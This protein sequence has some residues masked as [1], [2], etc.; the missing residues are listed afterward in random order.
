MMPRP[1]R[2]KSAA[3]KQVTSCRM[4]LKE[5]ESKPRIAI[6]EHVAAGGPNDIIKEGVCAAGNYALKSLARAL[7][8]T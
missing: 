1:D 5:P 2:A 6:V 8:Q 4:N 7:L 3:D